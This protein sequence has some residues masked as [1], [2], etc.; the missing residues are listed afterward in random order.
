MK[1]TRLVYIWLFITLLFM[2]CVERYY[3]EDDDLFTGTLVVNAHLTDQPGHQTISISR[4]DRL[5]FPEYIPES[6][7]I[8]EVENENSDQVR[9]TEAAPGDYT[10]D[11]PAGFM[12]SGSRY[13]LRI[14]TSDGTSYESEYAELHP[15]AKLDSVYYLLESMPTEEP[16][17]T[18]DGI[19]FYMDFE[20]DPEASEYMRWDLIETYE[21]HNPDY[22][23]FIYDVDRVVRPIPDSMSDRQCWITGYVPIIYTRDL[24][25]INSPKYSF[26][27][28]HYVSN[29]TQRLK[30]GYS[31]LVRQF[32]MD[33]AAFRYWDEL[34]KNSQE[35]SGLYDRQPSFTPSNI[36]NCEDPEEKILGFFSVSGVSEKRIFVR[37]VEGLEVP[38]RIFC[39]PTFEPPRLR[40]MLF[41]DLPIFMSRAL[42]PETGETFF[43]ETSRRCL[44]CRLYRGSS[45]ESPEF[46]QFE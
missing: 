5:V 4:S 46:W 34:K 19:R 13:R 3:P 20:V 39:F 45:G 29:E 38:D 43:G 32:S 30:Y 16:G 24:G 17:E 6:N 37:N 31:L 1:A 8:V 41:Q 27:P 25:N 44:D 23:G 26:M 10:A 36:C 21:F 35:M 7:C 11:M 12:Y 42:W 14:V 18:I 9:F 40:Y 22:D 15:S 28:L 33:E 2:G